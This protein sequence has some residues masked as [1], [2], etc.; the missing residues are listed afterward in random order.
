MPCVPDPNA[1]GCDK[2]YHDTHLS[3]DGG[4]HFQESAVADIDKGKMD[5]FVG[6]AE[7]TT[8]DTKTVGCV[9]NA[10]PPVNE[11]APIG[12]QC[13][14]VMGYH[15]AAEI[16][17]YWTYAHDFVLQDHMF[18][19]AQAW[20]LVSH[21]Y[22]VSG[23]SAQCSN[24]NDPFTCTADNRFP[25][26]DPELSKLPGPAQNVALEDAFAGVSGLATPA[27]T[28]TPP[29]YAWTDITYLLHRYGV[30]LAVLHPGGNG[31]RLRDRGDDV[32][33][34]AQ[35]VR[36]RRSGIRCPRSAT[37]AATAR[38]AT[39]SRRASCSPT[40][41]TGRFRRSRGWSRAATTPSTRR[42]TSPPD[43]RTSRT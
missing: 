18:E 12:D 22:T 8:P 33:P 4:P 15:T 38:R 40:R 11:P 30:E 6:Q 41:R 43:S 34:G 23:W 5:G 27:T 24:G 16:P 19:P 17:N 1:G 7:G 2:P 25:E 31:A 28:A 35:A 13:L 32:H 26:Y 20:S 21:L 14:D 9:V 29:M 3:G 37:S 10:E 42:R 36:R 39:S